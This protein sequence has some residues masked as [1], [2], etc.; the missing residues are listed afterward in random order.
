M[1]NTDMT[2]TSSWRDF[3]IS[4]LQGQVSGNLKIIINIIVEFN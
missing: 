1:E 4:S 2:I 3:H